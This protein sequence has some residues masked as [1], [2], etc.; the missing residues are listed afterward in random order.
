MKCLQKHPRGPMLRP[1]SGV[2]AEEEARWR[3]PLLIA[4]VGIGKDGTT[5]PPLD[6]VHHMDVFCKC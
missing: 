1:Y 2:L 5:H 6:T 4:E 3:V